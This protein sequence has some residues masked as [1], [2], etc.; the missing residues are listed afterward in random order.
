MIFTHPIQKTTNKF[1]QIL[2][3]SLHFGQ[4]QARK[5]LLKIIKQTETKIFRSKLR[6]K[7]G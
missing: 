1:Q 7:Q 2:N 3:F 6:K 5:Q 4:Q